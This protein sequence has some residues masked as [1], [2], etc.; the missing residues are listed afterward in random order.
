MLAKVP[1]KKRAEVA[2]MLKAVH[3]MGPREAAEAKTLE[4]ASELNTVKLGEG[5]REGYPETP[6]CTGFPR[7]HWRRIRTDNAIER[8]NREL[9]RRTRVEGTFSDGNSALMLVTAR[10]KY[11]AES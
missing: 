5:G 6:A 3:A 10:L 11:V 7:E 2:A 4:A 8:F 1:K 9:R